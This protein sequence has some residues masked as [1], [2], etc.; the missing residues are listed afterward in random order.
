V[1][2]LALL[3]GVVIGWWGKGRWAERQCTQT[4]GTWFDEASACGKVRVKP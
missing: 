1:L 3:L 4:G 2:T